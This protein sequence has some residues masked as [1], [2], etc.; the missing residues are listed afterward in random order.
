MK[1]KNLFVR[2]KVNVFGVNLKDSHLIQQKWSFCTVIHHHTNSLIPNPEIPELFER[3]FAD[4]ILGYSF[5]QNSNNLSNAVDTIQNYKHHGDKSIVINSFSKNTEYLNEIISYLITNAYSDDI[6]EFI[7]FCDALQLFQ[8]IT[9]ENMEEIIDILLNSG[10]VHDTIEIAL[11][12][13]LVTPSMHETIGMAIC[14]TPWTDVFHHSLYP[15][16][17]QWM[18]ILTKQYIQYFNSYSHLIENNTDILDDAEN[19]EIPLIRPK[20]EAFFIYITH[21]LARDGMD[22]VC[23]ELLRIIEPIIANVG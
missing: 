23:K 12:Y 7:T 21:L 15:L 10:R 5:E 6:F 4:K 9:P 1:V 14:S 13:K 2:A 16:I 17:S 20:F 8:Y 3:L 19:E 11:K 22:N 18:K